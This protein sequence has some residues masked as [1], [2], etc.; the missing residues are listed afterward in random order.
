M[1]NIQLINIKLH[2]SFYL[3]NLA[4]SFVKLTYLAVCQHLPALEEELV[5]TAVHNIHYLCQQPFVFSTK[6]NIR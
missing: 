1:Q 2:S 5:A 3:I 6:W 4:Y